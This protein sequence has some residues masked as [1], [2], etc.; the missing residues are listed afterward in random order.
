MLHHRSRKLRVAGRE[1]MISIT[2]TINQKAPNEEIEMLMETG[3]AVLIE[4]GRADLTTTKPQGTC[5]EI[6]DE[7]ENKIQKHWLRQKIAFKL[8]RKNL[9]EFKRTI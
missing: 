2:E 7:Y 3:L 1:E 9:I 4:R 5:E 8:C 6:R